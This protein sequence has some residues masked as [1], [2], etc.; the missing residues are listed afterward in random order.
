MCAAAAPLSEKQ[1]ASLAA[2]TTV[3]LV[4]A[5]HALESASGPTQAFSSVGSLDTDALLARHAALEARL[6]QMVS[7]AKTTASLVQ[8]TIELLIAQSRRHAASPANLRQS[9]A[10]LTTEHVRGWLRALDVFFW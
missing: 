1:L 2:G 8:R 6:Q 4:R 3:N 9:L 5:I 10:S 7:A